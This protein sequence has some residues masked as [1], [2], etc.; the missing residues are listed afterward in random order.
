M[1]NIWNYCRRSDVGRRVIFDTRLAL[2]LRYH[3]VTE[4]AT[5]NK[6]HFESFDFDHVWNPLG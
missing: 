3:G 4:F 1:N 5:P 2:T 6:K